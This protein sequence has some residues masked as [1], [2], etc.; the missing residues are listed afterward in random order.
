MPNKPLFSSEQERKDYLEELLQEYRVPKCLFPFK[1]LCETDFFRAPA[2]RGHHAAYSGGLF[3]HCVNVTRVLLDW[4]TA[5]VSEQWLRPESPIIVGMLHDV[6][7][8]GMYLP[9][10]DMNPI[11]KEVESCYISN[12]MFYGFGG[13]GNDSVCKLDLHCELTEEERLCIRYHMGA[14]ETKDWDDFDKAIKQYPNVLWTHTADMIAS[15]L[16]ED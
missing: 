9:T 12:P 15:K 5:K 3:D 11:T 1:W 6:T 10:M 4:Q 13:H 2:S 14:Y 7:K 16:M 8:I